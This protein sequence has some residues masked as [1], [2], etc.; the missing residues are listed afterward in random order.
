MSQESRRATRRS[1]AHAID[2]IDTMTG[3]SLG[4]LSN[5]SASGLLLMSNDALPEEALYQVQF[6]LLDRGGRERT[7]VAGAQQLWSSEA[8][9]PGNFWNGMRFIDISQPD[10]DFLRLWAESPGLERARD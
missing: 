3:A 1:V 5:L 6:V 9:A 10:S 2:V 8:S 4:R 7:I